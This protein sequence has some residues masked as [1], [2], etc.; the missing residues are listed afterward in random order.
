MQEAIRKIKLRQLYNGGIT[1]WDGETDAHWWAS[2]YAAHFLYEAQ[3]AGYDVDKSLLETLLAYLNSRLR[4]RETITYYYNKDQQKKIVPKEVAY[5]LYVL[6]LAG[7]PNVSV[8]NFYKANPGLLA[9]DSRYLL[10]A[11]YAVAGDKSRFRELLPSAFTGEVSVAQTGGSF[12]SD[13]RDEAIALDA[14]VDADPAN[15][16]IGTMAKHV[17]DKLKQRTWYS[18]Q[19]SAFSF[20]ALGKIARINNKSTATATISVNGKT[21]G[22]M[23]GSTVK[24]SAKQ[25]GGSEVD[26]SSK[27]EGT[28]F[29]W[30]QSEGISVSGAYKE[31]DNYIRVRRRFFDRF[32]RAITGNTFKQNDLVIVQLSL[33]RSYNG[34]IENIA[35]TD[36]LPA[37]FEI[38]NPRTKE[39]P[40][41]D[42][43]KDCASYAHGAGCTG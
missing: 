24:L 18:T 13:I 20:L 31:E 28:L 27:G 3:R 42:W 17:A 25:L 34:D 19:E 16:Q 21:V 10:S 41:M 22:V 35:L 32:G 11:A 15:A 29:Y 38:E 40:G 37:G 9:L 2:V 1:L 26:I 43:I 8:M 5:S 39:I 4:N 36:L 33:E 12:Y 6:A 23:N 14:L 7:R 30:W